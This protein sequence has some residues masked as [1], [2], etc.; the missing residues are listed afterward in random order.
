MKGRFRAQ[1]LGALVGKLGNLGLI[2]YLKLA[3]D[4]GMEK[5]MEIT[6][7]G[8]YYRFRVEGLERMEKNMEIT[9]LGF[10]GTTMRFMPSCLATHM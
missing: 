6:I 8:F 5:K 10:I 7:M 2:T 3:M 1:G 9:I 4:E